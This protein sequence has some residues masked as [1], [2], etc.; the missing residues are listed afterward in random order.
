MEQAF[1]RMWAHLTAKRSEKISGRM[2]TYLFAVKRVVD[3]M[4]LRGQQK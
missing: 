2:A 4:L 1:E 3:N